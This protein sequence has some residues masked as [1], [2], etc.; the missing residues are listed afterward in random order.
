MH[1]GGAPGSWQDVIQMR[2]MDLGQRPWKYLREEAVDGV[3]DIILSDGGFLRVNDSYDPHNL[4]PPQNFAPNSFEADQYEVHR[5]FRT[6]V[7]NVPG[8][9]KNMF[10]IIDHPQK[11]DYVT[12]PLLHKTAVCLYNFLKVREGLLGEGRFDWM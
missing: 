8:A 7:E 9:I 3:T 12:Q 6:L 5:Q 10:R 1:C 4:S 2:D 11:V